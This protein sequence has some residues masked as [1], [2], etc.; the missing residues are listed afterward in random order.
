MEVLIM[1]QVKEFGV[2]F[3]GLWYHCRIL[4]IVCDLEPPWQ[5]AVTEL[6]GARFKIALTE[7]RRHHVRRAEPPSWTI[8]FRTQTKLGRRMRLSHSLR[9]GDHL[10]LRTVPRDS[11]LQMRRSEAMPMAE[12]FVRKYLTGANLHC[13]KLP[14]AEITSADTT[15]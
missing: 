8:R 3:Q 7:V 9:E 2:E 14:T 11:T 15:W 6:R 1:D 10:D 13:D 4:P 5:N 12:R